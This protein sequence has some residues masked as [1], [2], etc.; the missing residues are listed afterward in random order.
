MKPMPLQVALMSVCFNTANGLLNGRAAASCAEC[1]CN[2]CTPLL[3]LGVAM[4]ALGLW[5]NID[6]DETTRRLRTKPEDADKYKIPPP[7]GMHRYLAS[8]NYSCETLEWVGYAVAA[9]LCPA[10]VSFVI[11]TLCNLV[12]RAVANR[13]WCAKTF[14]DAYPKDRR[15]FIPFIW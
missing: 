8:P 9:R 11:W 14:D 13:R 10:A 3:V 7:R 15:I 5:G 6:A 1:G 12:P 4:W 2:T